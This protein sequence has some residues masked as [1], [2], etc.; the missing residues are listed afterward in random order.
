V[1]GVHEGRAVRDLVRDVVAAVAVGGT[2]VEGAA[3]GEV[4]LPDS[5]RTVV[6]VPPVPGRGEVERP[7]GDDLVHRGRDVV[8]L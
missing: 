7:V 6:E 1:E 5:G 8:V 3:G 4:A 2:A